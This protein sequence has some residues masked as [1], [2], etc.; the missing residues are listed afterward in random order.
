M[1]SLLFIAS[2]ATNPIVKQNQN[3]L[4]LT[5]V[6]KK[7]AAE[8]L[9]NRYTRLY[10]SEDRFDYFIY[11][12]YYLVMHNLKYAKNSH[13]LRFVSD[14]KIDQTNKDYVAINFF[15]KNVNV[16]IKI[17]VQDFVYMTP[18]DCNSV[19]PAHYTYYMA[20]TATI[21]NTPPILYDLV[22]I[23]STNWSG[24]AKYY[25][26]CDEERTPLTNSN[27]QRFLQ[28][29]DTYDKKTMVAFFGN[30]LF[31]GYAGEVNIKTD[32]QTLDQI[33]AIANN[34]TT[35]YNYSLPG[36]APAIEQFPINLNKSNKLLFA[37]FAQ[38]INSEK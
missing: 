38:A 19:I 23:Y 27:Y 14:V 4:A 36:I 3:A 18:I 34:I 12:N 8:E 37:I 35:L 26:R 16:E 25:K 13:Y 31:Y 6:I 5:Q 2:C 22:D 30:L 21:P 1:I 32:T 10:Y 33:Y 20:N 28:V 24:L 17:P 7:Y 11:R 15:V 29:K 9:P